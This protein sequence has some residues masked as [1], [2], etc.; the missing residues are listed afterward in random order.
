MAAPGNKRGLWLAVIALAVLAVL[1]YRHFDLGQLLT[2][3]HL[4]ASRDALVA[5][6]QQRPLVTAAAF[7]AVYVAATALSY[8]ELATALDRP[9]GT[10]KAQ[11]HRGLA[12][13]RTAFEAAQR[14]EREELTA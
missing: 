13:L 8:P 7:F 4:K 2:L 14:R 9:E 10:V 6:V 3:D 11:V 1:A 12:L 5:Q